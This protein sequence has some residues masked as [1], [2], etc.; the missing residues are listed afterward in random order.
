MAQCQGLM[1]L[2]LNFCKCS[3]HSLV[4]F[5][6]FKEQFAHKVPLTP[7]LQ[8]LKFS[9]TFSSHYSNQTS[10]LAVWVLKIYF[11]SISFFILNINYLSICFSCL[12][13]VPL[14]GG[15]GCLNYPSCLESQGCH[16]IPLSYLL[17]CFFC[18]VLLLFLS[19]HVSANGP[20]SWIFSPENS[21]IFR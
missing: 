7:S 19:C 20:F 12:F 1:G 3:G 11:H 13:L 21:N 6:L 4:N 2:P 17:T 16:L 18:L 9:P 8:N 10:I 15:Q 5:W 14:K